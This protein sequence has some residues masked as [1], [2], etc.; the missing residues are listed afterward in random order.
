MDF[1]QADARCPKCGW[2]LS[3]AMIL[4]AMGQIIGERVDL[5]CR[6]CGQLIAQVIHCDACDTV[7]VFGWDAAPAVDQSRC[8]ACGRKPR[9][10]QS[11]LL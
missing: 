10:T 3:V 5:S 11:R 2:Q 6:S 8:S 7:N 9:Q 4:Y 1:S